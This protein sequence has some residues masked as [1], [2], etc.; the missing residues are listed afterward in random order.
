M[1]TLQIFEITPKREVIHIVLARNDRACNDEI[2]SAR[3]LG[4]RDR[5]G[6]E[7]DIRKEVAP[8]QT[9]VGNDIALS[10]SGADFEGNEILYRWEATN[11]SIAHASA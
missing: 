4:S 1:V 10:A 3:I 6:R 2:R 5:Q 8:L 11:G 9:S 7:Q